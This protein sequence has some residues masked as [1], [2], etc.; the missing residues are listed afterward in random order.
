MKLNREVKINIPLNNITK[1]YTVLTSEDGINWSKIN[2]DNVKKISNSTDII[3][4]HFSYFA[5]VDNV[6]LGPP[7]NPNY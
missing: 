4:N 6:V 2:D 3:T 7:P 1:S 5:I